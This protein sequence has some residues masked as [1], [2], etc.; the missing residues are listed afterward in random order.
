MITLEDVKKNPEVQELVIGAQ[1]QLDALGYTEHS[2]RHVS[3]VSNRA[4]RIL[5]TLGYDKHRVELA[6]IAGYL[7]DIG[8]AVNRVEHAHTGAILAYNILKDMGMDIKERTEIMSAIGNHEST[9]VSDISAALILADKSDVHR[10]RILN[11]N[12]TTFEIYDKD[13]YPVTNA[14]LIVDNKEKKVTLDLTINN[15]I[16]SI[17]DYYEIVI[18]RMMMSKDAANYL[19]VWFELIINDTKLL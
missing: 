17:L 19:K 6:K 10:D 13:N 5:E 14:E 1:K 18:N 3:I 9:V 2:V 16:C 15:K 12:I 7:H 8:N 4:G 11:K